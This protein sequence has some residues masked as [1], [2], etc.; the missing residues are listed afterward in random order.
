MGFCTDGSKPLK[1]KM[2]GEVFCRE[3]SINSSF[4]LPDHCS[5]LQAEVAAIKLAVD[6]LLRS[7]ASF[8]EACIHSYSRAAIL[9]DSA[10]KTSQKGFD[11]LITSV[12]LVGVLIG[13]NSIGAHAVRLHFL[14]DTRH[15]VQALSPLM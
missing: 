13:Q 3:L 1:G 11:L 2:E 9:A 10:L 14:S 7:A 6:V 4:R 15:K 8:K 12:K 5:V